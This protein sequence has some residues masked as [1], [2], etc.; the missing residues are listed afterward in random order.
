MSSNSCEDLIQA[1]KDALASVPEYVAAG[2]IGPH[3][4]QALWNAGEWNNFTSF[5]LLDGV[6]DTAQ[7]LRWA[8]RF[9]GRGIALPP[10]IPAAAL[11]VFP[12]NWAEWIAWAEN[13]TEYQTAGQIGPQVPASQWNMAAWTEW[14]TDADG[15]NSQPIPGISSYVDLVYWGSRWYPDGIALSALNSAQHFPGN[16][17]AFNSW[18][19]GQQVWQDEGM[20]LDPPAV[21]NKILSV[22]RIYDMQNSSTSNINAAYQWQID[23][24][25]WTCTGNQNT[26]H[27]QVAI[28][29]VAFK[30]K[31]N[32]T[33]TLTCSV[34]SENNYDWLMIGKLDTAISTALSVAGG[35][36][37]EV[38]NQWSG[39]QTNVQSVFSNLAKG[40][41][42]IDIRWSKDSSS[43]GGT[44]TATIHS[45]VFS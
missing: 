5:G 31:A 36:P 39:S 7:F 37:A 18:A 38:T 10:S 34:S 3:P 4:P 20:I 1:F 44:D 2:K 15:W 43:Y 35:L 13:V 40:E 21:S 17:Q 25:P 22:T 16:L 32:A 26:I 6:P 8:N 45:L 23:S 28:I 29:R 12:G 11:N 19:N 27:Y 41:H 33:L 42:Y 9:A 30:C 24:L 14:Y